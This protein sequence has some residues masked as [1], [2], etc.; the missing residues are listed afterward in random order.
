MEKTKAKRIKVMAG[1]FCFLLALLIGRIFYIQLICGEELSQLANSQY[2]MPIVGLD[3]RGMILDRN[4]KPLTGGTKEYYYIIKKTSLIGAKKELETRLAAKQLAIETSDYY[5]FRS[6][7][8][9]DDIGKELKHKYGAYIFES[10]SRYADKQMACHLIGYLNEDEQKGV[11]GLEL[12]YQTALQDSQ[13]SVNLWADAA[14]GLLKGIA[15]SVSYMEKRSLGRN[16]ITTIDRRLQY[17]CEK[18][19]QEADKPGAVLV[20]ESETGEILSWASSPVFNPNDIEAYLNEDGNCLVDKV[21]Q[22]AYAPGSVFKI[23]TA[24]AAL[25]SGRFD[26]TKKYICEGTVTIGG[27]E[28]SCSTGGK[29]GHGGI[30]MTEAMAQSCNCYFSNLG[31]DVGYEAVLDMARKMGLGKKCFDAFPGENPGNVPAKEETYVE[32]TVNISIGQGKLLVTPLQMTQ[33][34]GIIANGGALVQPEMT[35]NSRSDKRQQIISRDNAEELDK[36]LQ[37][38][39]VSGTGRGDWD[40]PVRGKTGTAEAVSKG[41]KINNCFFSGYFTVGGKNYVATVLVVDGTSGAVDA[42][43]VF[44]AIHNYFAGSL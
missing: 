12:M 35:F 20:E 30:D 23:V 16:L 6:E 19:L 9:N 33:M 40:L 11:S 7:Q 26:V 38:V 36:M 31:Y 24:A 18:A 15:P 43:P 5:V 17:I 10:E 37:E 29:E 25:E 2:K 42:V 8:Y 13:C 3:A 28:V 44:E 21:S 1:A 4:L 41:R 39:M 22:G 32:D 14:G 34:L 27:V